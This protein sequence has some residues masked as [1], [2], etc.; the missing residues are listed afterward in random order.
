MEIPLACSLDAAHA[1]AQLGEWKELLSRTVTDTFRA[2]PGR[3]EL[4]LRRELHDVS[5]LV[6]LAQRE[7]ACCP[8]FEFTLAIEATHVTLVAEVPE[9]ASSILDE[10]VARVGQR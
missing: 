2:A 5:A 10:F 9:D 4:T 3:L 1:R 6:E 8:F 7:K